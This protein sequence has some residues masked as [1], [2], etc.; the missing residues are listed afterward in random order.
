MTYGNNNHNQQQFA[1]QYLDQQIHNASPAQQIVMLYDGA[2]RFLLKAKAAI[3]D[4]N[5]QERCN[6]N[7]RALEIINYLSTILDME[8]GGEISM[9]LLR[10]YTHVSQQIL[11]VDI[12]NK[13][14][15]VDDIIPHL[16]AL[17]QSWVEIDKQHQGGGALKAQAKRD[18]DLAKAKEEANAPK[19]APT[20]A[21]PQNN[22]QNSGSEIPLAKRT[23]L[24]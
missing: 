5:I 7:Q 13:A 16:K 22:A 8:N 19:P 6:N 20:P 24:A 10:I 23:A 15:L 2:I 18:A 12:Q 1:R 3:I 17:R 21:A 4:N 11:E 14:E 9:R